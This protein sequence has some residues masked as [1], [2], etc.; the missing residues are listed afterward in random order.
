MGKT[1]DIILCYLVSFAKPE[2]LL[3]VVLIGVTILMP[4]LV[5]YFHRRHIPKLVFDGTWKQSFIKEDT[6]HETYYL[7]I[8]REKGEGGAKGVIGFVGLEDKELVQTA[9]LLSESKEVDIIKH[10]YLIL[11]QLIKFKGTEA[12]A[13]PQ[14]LFPYT[15]SYKNYLKQYTKNILE[16]H[17]EA[18]QARIKKRHFKKKIEDIITESKQLS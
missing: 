18:S 11:F 13:F 16:I 9:W 4:L 14:H 3:I 6:N 2:N 7:K 12:I 5:Y 15:P 17:I 10:D 8:K 1:T